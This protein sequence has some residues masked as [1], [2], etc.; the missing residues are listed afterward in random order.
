MHLAISMDKRVCSGP[1][2]VG[3][4]SWAV[5]SSGALLGDG[6]RMSADRTSTALCEIHTYWLMVF[7]GRASNCDLWALL[8]RWFRPTLRHSRPAII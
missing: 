4:P 1:N 3:S 6:F 2:L 7:E 8:G 5:T